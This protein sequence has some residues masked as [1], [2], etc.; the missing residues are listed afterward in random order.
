MSRH[1]LIDTDP[2]IDDALA[3]LLALSSPEAR[4]E[5][6]TTVAGNVPLERATINAQR[7]LA[8]AAPDPMPPVARGAATPLKRALV[9][10]GHVHG[11]DG[12]GNLERFVEPDGRPRY[13]EPTHDLE[14][15]PAA[16]VILEAVD[17]WGAD[18]TI[19]ALGPLT[20]LAAALALDARRL[21][22]AGRV[23]VMGGAIAVPGN[24]TPAAEFNFYV[25][26][27]AAAVVLEAGLNLELISLDVTRRV[28]LA[29]A[30]L[31]YRLRRCPDH[32]I[33]RF[34]LDFTRHGFAFGA[35]R[36]DGGIVLHDPLAMAVALDPS[37]VTFEPLSVEV[38]CEGKLTRGLSRADR[39]EIPSHRKRAPACRVAVDVDAARVLHLVLERLC[40]ASA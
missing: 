37:L 23:V 14:M 33:A 38:E 24:I 10:A 26:P 11:Q 22:R 1:L 4:V 32:R 21:A 16:E 29:Q 25:D 30:A 9:T 19:V 40:P 12:L 34:I 18:L 36:E 2:G 28:V 7:I 31:T 39:R 20:N 17:R 35:E 6:V 5:A 15:R 8:V 13:P 3:I 27:E